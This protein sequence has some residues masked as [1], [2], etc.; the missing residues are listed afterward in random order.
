MAR[1]EDDFVVED[2]SLAAADE[3]VKP[4]PDDANDEQI[5]AAVAKDPELQKD[6]SD[7]IDESNIIDET[8]RGAKP[9]GSYEE[10]S[11]DIPEA[12]E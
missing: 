6:L 5:D 12:D 1:A 4:V 2:N 11:D 9:K 10:P 3:E 8:T 7:G